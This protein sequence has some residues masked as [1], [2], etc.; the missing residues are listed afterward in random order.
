MQTM[1][2]LRYLCISLI[3]LTITNEAIHQ[4]SELAEKV[5][6]DIMNSNRSIHNTKASKLKKRLMIIRNHISGGWKYSELYEKSAIIDTMQMV[7]AFFT[8]R[9]PKL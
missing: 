3:L 2:S 5:L 9:N 8:E 6:D 1:K 4:H 7:W